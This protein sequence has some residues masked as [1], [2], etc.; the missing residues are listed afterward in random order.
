[1]IMQNL[2]RLHR[3]ALLNVHLW[4]NVLLLQQT[5]LERWLSSEANLP[6]STSFLLM[7]SFSDAIELNVSSAAWSCLPPNLQ[8]S[9]G[10]EGCCASK[11]KTF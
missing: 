2:S 10:I 7:K 1:M 9:T 4:L 8:A 3:S 6:G 5:C 11:E